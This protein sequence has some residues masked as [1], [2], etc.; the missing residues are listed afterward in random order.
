MDAAV[1]VPV[2]YVQVASWSHREIGGAVKGACPT[3]D[4][5]EI[6]AIIPRIRRRVHDPKGH[7][8]LALGGE[9]ADSMI[10]VV[11]AEDRAVR[12]DRDAMGA[13]R[14]LPFAPGTEK[15][16]LLIIDEDGV[17]PAANEVDAVLA[18]HRHTR[19]VP[20]RVARG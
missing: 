8:E 15:V 9:L 20:V 3:R 19:H 13:G 18:I 2:G 17:I 12:A 16:P 14:K 7:E 11:R 10:T 5:H 4:G 6:L 1:A